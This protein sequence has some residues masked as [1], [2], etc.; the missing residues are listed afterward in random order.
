MVADWDS[1][2]TII[3]PWDVV[4]AMGFDA[5]PAGPLDVGRGFGKLIGRDLGSPIG[6]YGLFDLTIAT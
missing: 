6:F 1:S 3:I 2:I 5:C 4:N